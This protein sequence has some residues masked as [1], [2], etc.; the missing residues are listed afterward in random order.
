MSPVRQALWVIE[1]HLSEPLTLAEIADAVGVSRHH[2]AHAFG[3]SVGMPVMHYVRGRRLSIAAAAL[4]D[5][6]ASILNLALDAGYGSH[7][8]FSRAFKTQFGLTP[9]AVRHRRSLTGLSI[10]DAIRFPEEQTMTL[11]DPRFEAA[12]P[13]H[14][15]GLAERLTLTETQTIA[16]QWKR[17]MALYPEISDKTDEPPIGVVMNMNEDGAFD[18]ICA[19]EVFRAGS[20]LPEGLSAVRIPPGRYAVFTHHGHATAIGETY[21]AI[22]DRWFPNS[23]TK[24]GDGATLERHLPTFD[25]KTGLGGVEVWI[26]IQD[27]GSAG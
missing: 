11:D 3:A 17:F 7:E 15:V 27:Q 1:R 6:E 24:P 10:A 20:R 21:A 2:L 23:K 12:G 18:Y 9:E 25:P 16:P 14:L 8:A 26:P 22:W 13:M 4:A 5:G 19:A